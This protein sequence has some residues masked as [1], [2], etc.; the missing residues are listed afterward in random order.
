LFAFSSACTFCFS[1][2]TAYLNAATSD[3]YVDVYTS[4]NSDACDAEFDKNDE[5]DKNAELDENAEVDLDDKNPKN[6]P[7]N[8]ISTFLSIVVGFLVVSALLLLQLVRCP[9]PSLLQPIAD[10]S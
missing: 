3:I 9:I 1:D 10:A 8:S 6:C 5:P 4:V 7:I 2:S